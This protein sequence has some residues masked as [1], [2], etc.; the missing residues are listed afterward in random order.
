MKLETFFEKF[1]QFADAPSAV[2]K[3]R[4]LV[5]QL[6]VQ[7][8]LVDQKRDDGDAAQLLTA[9]S[10]ERDARSGKL[11]K[12]EEPAPADADAHPFQIPS[13]WAWTQLGKIVLQIQYG[14][15]ASAD[16]NATEIRMLRI[17]DIQNNRVVWPSVPGCEI[18]QGEAEK[19]LLSPNDILIAR[20]GGTIGKSFIV[21]DAP[22]K[23]V[24]ASYLIR[25]TPPRSMAARYLKIFL[26]SPLY[27]TQLRAMSAGTGQP[28]VNG[29]ALG[30]LELPLPPLAEQNRIVAK[31]DELMALCDRLEAQQQERETRHAALARASLAR[32]ADAPTP[33]NL[34]FLFHPS[35][36]IPPADLRKFILTLAVQGKLIPQD[37]NHELAQELIERISRE[38]PAEV[39]RRQG[40]PLPPLPMDSLQ[41]EVPDSWTW[42]RFRDVAVIASNLVNP[43]DYPDFKHLAPDSI[44]KGN[45]VLLPCATVR[46]DKVISSKH[47]FYPGQIVYSKIRP[48]LAKVVVVDFVGLCSADMYPIN[49]LIDAHY[50]QRYMLSESFLIQ[51]VKTDT[52]VAMPKI[53]QNE[54]NAIAV[55]VPPLCEQRRI[56]AKVDQ[57]MAL[58]DQLEAQLA[59]SRATAMSL[60]NAVVVELTAASR[61]RAKLSD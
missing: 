28:N 20:T 49:A 36:T 53:N 44:G 23:S 43:I 52:R 39:R 16:P 24:F 33:A 21:P 51:A 9:I 55:P 10:R 2:A 37:P 57:L 29:Q 22:V 27:W 13:T 4:E 31:V 35:H 8:K 40:P 41:Y 42:A 17:T 48:N 45:G 3:M 58:V 5:L 6:A 34:N 14:Y 56:V 26:E 15:T 46:E 25:V 32:F 54:L 61:G 7:G 19:Y 1:D 12:L 60:M 30:R 59:A 47:R 11:R 18:G 50:L 38:M